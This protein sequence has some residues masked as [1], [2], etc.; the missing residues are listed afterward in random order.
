MKNCVFCKIVS[1]KLESAK[2]WEDK[3]FFAILD[4]YGN[5]KGQALVITK[6]HYPSY[7]FDLPDSFYNR[8]MIASKKVAKLLDKKLKIKRTAMVM[9][10]MGIDHIH[11]KLYPLHGLEKK[12]EERIEKQ[13]VFFDK[14]PNYATTI[15]GPLH[16]MKELKKLA[17]K[18]RS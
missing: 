9:E 2:I 18:I 8:L 12:F 14:Y 11:I 5:T 3:D 17:A 1:G 10:G 4:I 6:K 7:A 13:E 16:N 15:L